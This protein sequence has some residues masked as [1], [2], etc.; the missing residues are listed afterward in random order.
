[1]KGIALDR[2][3]LAAIKA[4]SGDINAFVINLEK[5]LAGKPDKTR[6]ALVAMSVYTIIA[7]QEFSKEDE[8]R[9]IDEL[10][11]VQTQMDVVKKATKFV[12]WR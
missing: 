4:I 12:G 5:I 6:R 3:S 11:G 1:M 2:A 8:D 7:S 9:L 10:H